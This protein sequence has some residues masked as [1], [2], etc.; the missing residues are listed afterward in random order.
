MHSQHSFLNKNLFNLI[1]SVVDHAF[2]SL[3]STV[4]TRLLNNQIQFRSTTLYCITETDL[5]WSYV[6]LAGNETVLNTTV[7]VTTSISTLSVTTDNPGYYSCQAI[8]ASVSE[9]FD[10]GILDLTNYTGLCI[11]YDIHCLIMMMYL[12]DCAPNFRI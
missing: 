6:D 3:N 5:P 9:I 2:G 8:I 1:L 7:N 4:Y 12:Y 11:S 10:I